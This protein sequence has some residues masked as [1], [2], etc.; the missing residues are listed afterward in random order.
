M[1]IFIELKKQPIMKKLLTLATVALLMTGTAFA[2]EGKNCGKD[3][4]CCKKGSKKECKKE[5]KAST[6]ST[7]KK[8]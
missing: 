2:H 8:A 6:A 7:M 3:K 4:A 1:I 5:D